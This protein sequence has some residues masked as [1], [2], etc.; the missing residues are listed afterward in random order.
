[1]APLPGA[2]WLLVVWKGTPDKTCLLFCSAENPL[3]GS[4]LIIYD[5]MDELRGKKFSPKDPD[6]G[7]HRIAFVRQKACISVSY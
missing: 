1:M 2:M 6:D 5:I 4:S 7:M 3:K